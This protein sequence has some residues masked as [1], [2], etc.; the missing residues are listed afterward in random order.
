[1]AFGFWK[2]FSLDS[3][4]AGTSKSDS[5]TPDKEYI[6]KRIYVVNKSGSA[7]TAS[8]FTLAQAG[9][10]YTQP[11]V[12][13]RLLSPDNYLNPELNLRIAPTKLD[14]AV[15]NGETATISVF[16]VFEVWTP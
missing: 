5:W 4:A 3:I 8:T 6:I 15:K 10:A 12:P 7:L 9:F 2:V 16:V 13:A 1:M 14:F 11:E